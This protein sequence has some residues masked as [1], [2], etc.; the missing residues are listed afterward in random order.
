MQNHF[1]VVA[2]R[3]VVDF[4]VSFFELLALR[5]KAK[6]RLRIYRNLLNNEERQNPVVSFL[7]SRCRPIT[8]AWNFVTTHGTW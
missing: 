1:F 3:R 5:R 2:K 4:M 8:K 6:A 7:K